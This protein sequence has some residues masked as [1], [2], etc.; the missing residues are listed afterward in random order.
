MNTLKSKTTLLSYT[1]VCDEY[2]GEHPS[3]YYA[4]YILTLCTKS[5]GGLR[6]HTF[7]EHQKVNVL[8][9]TPSV[10]EGLWD[11]FIEGKESIVIKY[12]QRTEED[13]F[14]GL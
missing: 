13:E 10:A 9:S 12:N 3:A 6:T 14:D 8:F 11:K 2:W 4:V 5:F 1:R 7:E